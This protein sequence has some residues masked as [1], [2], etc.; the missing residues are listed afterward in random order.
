MLIKSHVFHA[1]IPTMMLVLASSLPCFAQD[2]KL[3]IQ[4]TPKEAYVFVDDHAVG[5]ASHHRKLKL[6]VGDHKVVLVNYGYTPVTRTVTITDGQVTSLEVALPAVDATVPPPYGAITIESVSRDA[7]LLNG[8]TPDFFVGHGD[9]FNHEWGWK[10]EL[11]V[12]PGTYQM[13]ILGPEGELWSGPV[14]VPANQRVVVHYPKGVVKTV[15]WPRGEKLSA[16]PRF[17]VG[18]ASATVAV[19]KP[20]AEL[21]ANAAQINCGDAS[22]LKW[23][24]TDAPSVAI[25]P[26]GAVA[27][28]GDQSVQPKQTTTYQLTALGPGG[29][30]TSSTTVN[31]NTAVQADLRLASPEIRYKRVG[32]K[33]VEQGSAAL[34]WTAANASAVSIDA[35]GTVDPSGNRTMPVTPK[36]TDAGPV[37][38]TVTYTLTATNVCGGS[39]SKTATLRIVGVIEAPATLAFNSVYFPTDV[40]TSAKMEEGIVPSQKV[41]LTSIAG[42][43]KKF[44]ENNPDAHLTL[45]GHADERG[46]NGYNKDLSDRRAAIA[47]SFLVEQGVPEDHLETQGL[48]DG[49]NLTADQVKQ[50]VEQNPE[51]SDEERQKALERLYTLVLANNRRVDI[52]LSTT[53]QES[54]HQYPFKAEDFATLVDRNGVSKEVVQMAGEKEKIKN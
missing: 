7:I 20:T 50:M 52:I 29:T 27:P 2:G 54:A 26:V 15:P 14:E 3:A 49:Q 23:S 39:D 35:L 36:K 19:A 47:K 22:Q 21:S 1:A 48:G 17:K 43:F 46:P 41:A 40:P 28:S 31:V 24:S 30:A 6:S 8:K 11:V 32:D 44:L 5:E 12:P 37:D 10:Q 9:E 33:V 25:T 13:T 38:E 51:L 42:D 53:G 4:V 16:L 18:T 45:V 34:N